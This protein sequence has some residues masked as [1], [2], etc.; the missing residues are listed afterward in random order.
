[1]EVGARV[2]LHL[3]PTCERFWIAE[4]DGEAVGCVGIVRE[5]DTTARLRT[6]YVEPSARGLGIGRRLVGE[7]IRFSR[8]AGYSAIVLWTLEV[9]AEARN[10]YGSAG[11]RMISSEP[12]NGIGPTEQ[13]ETWRLELGPGSTDGVAAGGGHGHGGQGHGGEAVG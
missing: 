11:F 3:D 8:E 9:L 10:L 5:D 6:M 13:D 4:K 2:L 1:M 12:W 7:C